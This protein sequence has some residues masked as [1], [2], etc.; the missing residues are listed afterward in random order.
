MYWNIPLGI[1]TFFPME[2][3][4]SKKQILFVFTLETYLLLLHLIQIRLSGPVV[5]Q[6]PK[7]G[8]LTEDKFEDR[9]CARRATSSVRSPCL[10]SK[11]TTFH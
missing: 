2:G 4:H 10:V 3:V 7:E 9:E 5:V 1:S 8:T 6:G 11:F